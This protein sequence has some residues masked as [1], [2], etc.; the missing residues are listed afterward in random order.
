M[1]GGTGMVGDPSFKDEARKLM[2]PELIE[3]NIDGIKQVFSNYLTFGDGPKR[4]DDGQQ[5]RLA[6]AAQLPRIP[7]RC[8]PHFSVNRMLSFD[9]A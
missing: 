7:A 1:G 2:T 4:C 6:A 8:R 3:S 5:R 9:S